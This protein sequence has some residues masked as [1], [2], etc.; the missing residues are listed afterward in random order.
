M[1]KVIIASMDQEISVAGVKKSLISA[2]LAADDWRASDRYDA[3]I[4]AIKVDGRNQE[5]QQDMEP[6]YMPFA[7]LDNVCDKN[8]IEALNAKDDLTD[9][10]KIQEFDTLKLQRLLKSVKN[11]MFCPKNDPTDSTKPFRLPPDCFNLRKYLSHLPWPPAKYAAFHIRI[12]LYEKEACQWLNTYKIEEFPTYLQL[13]VDPPNPPVEPQQMLFQYSKKKADAIRESYAQLQFSIGDDNIKPFQGLKLHLAT[14]TPAAFAEKFSKDD[15]FMSLQTERAFMGQIYN[16][17]ESIH[18]P[19][20]YKAVLRLM[21]VENMVKRAMIKAFLILLAMLE[22]PESQS[23]D[24]D[25]LVAD[26]KRTFKEKVVMLFTTSFVLS[27]D[28]GFINGEIFARSVNK[29]YH[30]KRM[31]L[32]HLIKANNTV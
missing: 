10:E 25:M 3:A 14:K 7:I 5:N 27:A 24:K 8:K 13:H 26:W 6:Q 4:L 20:A 22:D 17:A 1:R 19:E 9:I 31:V 28:K 21:D 12:Q 29:S 32:D 30:M 23:V 18:T 15:L 11:D 16:Q 2:L